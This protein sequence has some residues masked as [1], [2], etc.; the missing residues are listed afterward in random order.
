MS[1]IPSQNFQADYIAFQSPPNYVMVV[2]SIFNQNCM[3]QEDDDE[4]DEDNEQ[5]IISRLQGILLEGHVLDSSWIGGFGND[6]VIPLSVEKN[7]MEK[8]QFINNSAS[9]FAAV[10]QLRT[11]L[12]QKNEPILH[13][14][15]AAEMVQ[16]SHNEAMKSFEHYL[17]LTSSTDKKLHPWAL[18][19]A[20]RL[21][22]KPISANFLSIFIDLFPTQCQ[23]ITVKEKDTNERA[24]SNCSDE[25][26][27][28]LLKQNWENIK[29]KY[30]V[31][32]MRRMI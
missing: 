15:M 9:L 32:S 19:V 7:L 2:S 12:K 18:V 31:K 26:R 5:E 1:G 8:M 30:D 21:T 16:H 20:A 4:T 10:E 17:Q 6:G 29:V 13:L 28:G 23:I 22:N 25:E 14:L 3:K 11:L 24:N 27:H